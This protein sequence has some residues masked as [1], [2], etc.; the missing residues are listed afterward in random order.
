MTLPSSS[1]PLSLKPRA[2]R[3][4][5]QPTKMLPAATA[6]GAPS[7]PTHTSPASRAL[8]I[9]SQRDCS[10]VAGPGNPRRRTGEWVQGLA[11]CLLQEQLQG[12]REVHA[13]LREAGMMGFLGPGVRPIL[14]ILNNA[15]LRAMGGPSSQAECS[16]RARASSPSH[17]D[18][19][20]TVP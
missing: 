12:R 7:I 11:Q 14:L 3:Q 13:P 15:Q 4:H 1:A 19:C 9:D 2:P 5:T 8:E 17:R 18:A 16:V 20:V 6:P 10:Q